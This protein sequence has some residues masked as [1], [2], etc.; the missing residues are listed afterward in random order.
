MTTTTLPVDVNKFDYII[1]GGGTA[2]CVIA[3]RLS[4]YL[5]DA[6]IL[7]IEGGPSDYLNDRVLLLKD[8]LSL[9]GGKLDYDYGTVEQPNGNSHIRHSRAKVLG[10]CSS[11]NTLISFR[12]F[13]QDCERWEQAGCTGWG[14]DTFMRLIDNL[15][16]NIQPVAER[17]R[18][19]L[20]LD[21]VQSCST[22]MDIPIIPDFNKHIRAEG[23]LKPSVGFFS[24]SYNPDDGRRSS[25]SVAY[26]HPILRGQEKRPNLTILTNAWAQK[27]NIQDNTVEG[28]TVKLE[29][30][31]V[32][33]FSAKRETINCCGAI[34]APSKSLLILFVMHDFDH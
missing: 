4:E 11:H 1:L 10:G 26:I 24:V 18:N 8:W 27:L 15:R 20:C 13:R 3:S 7:M 23:S 14:F 12:P 31:D 5:P 29:N 33:E 17:H 34:D 21:W 22:S 30:G 2:G 32:R 9:L 28:V 6:T 19:Q 25:A 16:N